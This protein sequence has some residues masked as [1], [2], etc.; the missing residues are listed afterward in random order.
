MPVRC[1]F[2]RKTV[3]A[4]L[5]AV[6]SARPAFASPD[7]GAAVQIFREARSIC[8]RDAGRFWGRA[9]CGP[10]LLVDPVDRGVIAN[11][12][13]A[14]G[15]LQASGGGYKGV[16]PPDV[17]LSDT[18]VEWEGKRWT[19]LL[20]PLR[21]KG[22]ES[23]TVGD[24][25]RA[26]MLAHEMF[27]RIQ[28]DLK[29]TRPE[30]GN[31]RLDTLD[32]RYLLQLEWRALAKALGAATAVERREAISDALLFEAERYRQFPD[33]ATEENDLEINEGIAEYTGVRL[34]LA[35]PGERTAYAIYDLSAFVHAPTFV[36]SFAYA[37]GPAYGLLLD[38]AHPACRSQLNS[39][40]TFHQLLGA[41][42]HLPEPMFSR[43]K[44]R[45]TAYDDGRLWLQEV[46]RDHERQARVAFLKS[47]LVDGP[48]L[49]LPLHHPAYQFS[50]QTL[51]PLDALGTVYPTI[52]LESDWG[53]LDVESGGALLDK[54][55]KT[56]AVS[57]V[58]FKPATLEGEGWRLTL[59]KGWA[60]APGV[61]KGDL[62][63]GDEAR[64]AH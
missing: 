51:M 10:M 48:V 45:E 59:K 47:L 34:G 7:P 57:A 35:T 5:F 6:L 22:Q 39:G 33:A 20:L 2:T 8:D 41:A 58:G 19:E 16:L 12:T 28:P 17:I 40:K 4:F 9:L 36:R 30:A 49:I 61:R 27:H 23:G 15:V 60:V 64:D 44:A 11:E 3:A 42:W 50:P 26:V 46:A 54:D 31:R 55:M 38:Q 21:P 13:D 43:L 25:W 56:A 14:A 37:M 1:F 29:L 53:V 18:P 63:V 24:A 62:I 32:G 52:R